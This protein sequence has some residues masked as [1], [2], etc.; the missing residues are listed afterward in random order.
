MIFSG[1][2]FLFAFL[3]LTLLGFYIIRCHVG[4]GASIG[5]LTLASLVFYS[6][7]N[8]KFLP[9]LLISIS[10]NYALSHKLNTPNGRTWLILGITFN[11]GLLGIFKYTDFFIRTGNTLF[12]VE[13]AETGIAL[14]LA[15]S[16][17]T[18]QQIAFLVDRFRRETEPAHPGYYPLFVAFFPQLIAGP[19]VH[20][21]NM[22]AQLRDT[23]PQKDISFNM[24]VGLSIF[25]V[26]LTKKLLLADNFAPFASQGFNICLLYTS[27]SPRDATLSRMP[28]SA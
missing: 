6:W 3:P 27:P 9:L 4:H 24:G 28:S 12:G 23:T 20:H 16:F 17:F 5:W 14:P 1:P 22:A 13:A 11:L 15:I 8:I 2:T 25:T 18:F 10:A 7:W 21:K 19:I 26:G